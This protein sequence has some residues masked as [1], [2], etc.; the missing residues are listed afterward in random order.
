MIILILIA[1]YGLIGM[2]SSLGAVLAG[3]MGATAVVVALHKVT[4]LQVDTTGA[5]LFASAVPLFVIDVFALAHG[6]WREL[7]T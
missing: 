2:L 4:I 7:G 1:F 3:L 5:V 6:M